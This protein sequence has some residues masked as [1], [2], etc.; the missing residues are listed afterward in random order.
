MLPKGPP[1]FVQLGRYGDIIQMLPAFKALSDKHGKRPLVVV[2][3]E[4]SAVFDGVSYVE[5]W[6]VPMTWPDG[7]QAARGLA[8]LHLPWVETPQFWNDA[9]DRFR[10]EACRQARVLQCHG[11]KWRVDTERW[12]DYGTA[13]WSLAGFSRDDMLTLPLVFDRRDPERELAL[14][15]LVLH[16][17]KP[18]VLVNWTGISSPFPWTPEFQRVLSRYRDRFNL[19]DLSSVKAERI[20]DLL[21]LYDRAAVLIT[22]DTAT[23]HLAPASKVPYIA[24]TRQDWSGSVPRG[25]CV[26]NLGY[27]EGI[28]RMTDFERILQSWAQ[29]PQ[30][31]HA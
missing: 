22:I 24:F 29:K 28:K 13:M 26:L 1:A 18:V 9:K 6:I 15:R 4:Y 23:L 21:G 11:N 7:V 20:Y 14:A 25:T 2:S 5:P 3:R 31:A 19:V 16:P 17:Y 30:L 10:S 12:P 8:E 27:D